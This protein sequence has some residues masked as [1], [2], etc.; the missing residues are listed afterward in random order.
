MPTM[1]VPSFEDV[2]SEAERAVD[3]MEI[4]ELAALGI[5]QPLESY[6]LIGTYPPLKAMDEIPPHE[7]LAGLTR[8]VNVYLHLPFCHQRCT[9]CHFAKEILPADERVARY[10]TALHREIDL[11][12]GMVK[13]PVEA[14][15]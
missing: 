12:T 7:A 4:E 11:V 14:A 1:T 9:F 13:H 15:T 3:E 8:A 5:L 2:L 10:L 6:Y